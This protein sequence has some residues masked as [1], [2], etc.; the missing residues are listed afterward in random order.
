MGFFSALLSTKGIMACTWAVESIVTV[1]LEKQLQYLDNRVIKKHTLLYG[2]YW[3]IKNSIG[4]LVELKAEK[5][6][7]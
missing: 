2:L 5:A 4:M 7:C 3:K 6:F 1:H